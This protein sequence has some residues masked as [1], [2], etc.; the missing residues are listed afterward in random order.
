MNG[1][2]DAEAD[3]AYLPVSTT[4]RPGESAETIAVERPAGTLVLDFDGSGHL[5]GIEVV[6]A[7]ALLR[8]SALERLDHIA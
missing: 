1:T 7:R 5:L 2:Y 4:L 3:A 6:G 8:S